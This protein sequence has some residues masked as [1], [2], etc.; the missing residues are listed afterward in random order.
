MSVTLARQ[1]LFKFDNNTP[2]ACAIVAYLVKAVTFCS[3]FNEPEIGKFF[4]TLQ[5]NSIVI[6][7]V[8]SP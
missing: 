6:C 8:E 1:Q 7:M 3:T 5:V 2:L 4:R